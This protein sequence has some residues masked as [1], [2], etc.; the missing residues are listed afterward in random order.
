MA[1]TLWKMRAA[2]G[3]F[4]VFAEE[5]NTRF[6]RRKDRTS[7]DLAGLSDSEVHL[8]RWGGGLVRHRRR[9]GTTLIAA[10]QGDFE[11][12]K[13]PVIQADLQKLNGD[14]TVAEQTADL[15]P[16]E[17]YVADNLPVIPTTTSADWFE[18]N[19][20]HFIGWPTQDNPYDSG[21]PSGTNNGLGTGS[22]EVVLLHLQPE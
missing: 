3:A 8:P 13:D 9:P 7:D 22:D 14:E 1:S 17:K 2:R 10:G 5:V 4:R 6:K 12:L 19:S 11:Q 20:Q 16:I 18:Y 21:Q 15:A